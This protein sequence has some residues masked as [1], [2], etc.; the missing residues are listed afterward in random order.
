MDLRFP[1]NPGKVLL[2]GVTLAGGLLAGDRNPRIPGPDQ[3]WAQAESAHFR[4]ITDCTERRTRELATEFETFRQVLTQITPGLKSGR[5][6]LSASVPTY[7]YLF[8]DP[9]DFEGFAGSK[10]WAGFFRRSSMAQFVAVSAGNEEARRT[11]YHEF[12]HTFVRSNFPDTP[13]WANEGL[14][15]FFSSMQVSGGEVVLGR[16]LL[17]HLQALLNQAPL[18]MSQLATRIMS[19]HDASDG[20][21]RAHF[22][23]S[24]WLAVHYLL[25]GSE[26]RRNQF[27]TFLEWLRTGLPQEEAF[28]RAFKGEPGSLDKELLNYR[29]VILARPRTMIVNLSTLPVP[30][31]FSWGPL[32]HP[33]ALGRLAMLAAEGNEASRAHSEAL[34]RQALA[35]SP[36]EGLAHFARALQAG[37]GD[38]WGEAASAMELAVAARPED[39][40]VRAF[41]GMAHYYAL[42]HPPG[43]ADA[44]AASARAR[45]REHLRKALAADLTQ[46]Q[47]LEHLLTLCHQDPGAA[48]E[49]LE[50]LER[51]TAQPAQDLAP[52]G[53]FAELLSRRGDEARSRAIW[54][55]LAAQTEQPALAEQA[56]A[57]LDL[58]KDQ[59]AQ[60]KFRLGVEAFEAGREAEGRRLIQEALAQVT[61]P[62]LKD[63]YEAYLEGRARKPVIT[64][65]GGSKPPARKGRP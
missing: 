57:Q 17:D 33:E 29:S 9:R 41:A 21:A 46:V 25:V 14:A 50:V 35:E 24:A 6:T 37:A 7:V 12:I 16:P 27:G 18:P 19:L 3:A 64:F 22:Y 43:L 15:D 55:R 45:A 54:E 1:W 40:E 2:L 53:R 58:A 8:D 13:S 28:R 26:P 47:V 34:S 63:S 59:A 60:A 51:A 56:R 10:G 48:G 44:P 38:R 23:A 65:V 39:P 4:F 49:A 61:S 5:Y 31:R 36:K 20:Q 32:P 11:V 62:R 30:S 42:T 52:L